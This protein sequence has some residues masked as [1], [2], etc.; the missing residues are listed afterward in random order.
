MKRKKRTKKQMGYT[1]WFKG[2]FKIT[3]ALDEKTQE[4]LIYLRHPSYYFGGNELKQEFEN[5]FDGFPNTYMD[6]MYDSDTES[7]IWDTETEK[8]YEY[9]EWLEY[10]IDE[11]F[12]PNYYVLNGAMTWFG[13]DEDDLGLIKIKNNDLEAFGNSSRFDWE[14]KSTPEQKKVDLLSKEPSTSSLMSKT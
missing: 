2:S 14:K 4:K 1:T 13:E 7:L 11:V 5:E 8:F 10:L 6:W 12:S 3:P 9:I